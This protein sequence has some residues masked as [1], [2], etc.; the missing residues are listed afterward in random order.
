[1]DSKKKKAV[2]EAVLYAMGNSVELSKLAD[3]I[4]ASREETQQLLE[5]INKKYESEESGLFIQELD[6]AYQMCTKP[7][8]YE[9]LVKIA[10][11]PKKYVLTDTVLET[12]SIIAYKQPVT[13]LEIEKVRG[14]SCDHAVN[15]LIEYDLIHEVGRLDAPGKPLLFGTTEQFLRSF[16]VRSITDLPEMNVDRV[17]EFRKQAEEEVQLKLDV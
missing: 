11:S 2:L 12:L 9:Y 6:G 4:D 7:A 15:R 5:D 14:V 10:K 3:V 8:M 16:G 13:R 1:M 17:E